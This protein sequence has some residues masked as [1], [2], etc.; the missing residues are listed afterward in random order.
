MKS[1]LW[2][3]TLM[4]ALILVASVI[5]AAFDKTA[6]HRRPA[7]AEKNAQVQLERL[8]SGR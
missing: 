3:E 6:T 5:D 2:F 8:V 7:G 1:H 4:L